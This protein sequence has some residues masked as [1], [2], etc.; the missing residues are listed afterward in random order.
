MRYLNSFF[1]F[2]MLLELC[3]SS[4]AQTNQNISNETLQF[5]GT[6]YDYLAYREW[7]TYWR[8]ES[9]LQVMKE[10]GFSWMRTGILTT[11][12]DLLVTTPFANWPSLGWHDEFWCSREFS[13]RVLYEGGQNNLNQ[14][15]FF[16][17]SDKATYAGQQKEPVAWT[18]YN[19]EQ[20]AAAMDNHCFETV[21]YFNAKGLN[22]KVYEMGNEI[23][24]GLCGF[25]PG[26]KVTQW[27]GQGLYLDY[28]KDSVWSKEVT[29]LKA[30]ISGTKR[31]DS[32][33]QVALHIGSVGWFDGIHQAFY[34][35]MM[36]NNVEFDLI[37][38]SYYTTGVPPGTPPTTQVTF[39][40]FFKLC[41][42]LE[43]QTHKKIIISEFSYPSYF[44]DGMGTNYPGYPFTEEGQASYVRDFIELCKSDI[45][46]FGIFYF[47]PDY[48]PAID[49]VL[50]VY[51]LFN[52]DVTPKQAMTAIKNA[53]TAID[54]NDP[55]NINTF[56]LGRNYP[57]PFNPST[58]IS[59]QL[60]ENSKVI[61]KV[62]NILGVEVATLVNEEKPAGKYEVEFRSQNS[63]KSSGVYF[64]QLR[65]GSFVQTKKMVLLR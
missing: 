41:T 35:Y 55:G 7:S 39:N 33:A 59:Y 62:F 25:Y 36:N 30:A 15:V 23:E 43:T 12:S 47:Y 3:N 13:E 45:N 5:G 14:D 2:V 32:T 42:S 65:A 1:L 52:N 48:Q 40:D 61:L 53:V 20:T 49:Q 56:S 28:L 6:V 4:S 60:S 51:G 31:A 37:G 26:G 44:V 21:N 38:L 17:F 34:E 18:T 22:V 27:N 50:G 63:E 57:N 24:Y 10:N 46:I 11:S 54:K 58:V 16:Y 29:L 64:Y 8:S 9:P 19:L